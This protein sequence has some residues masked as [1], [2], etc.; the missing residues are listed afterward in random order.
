MA[1]EVISDMYEDLDS[2]ISV[3]TSDNGNDSRSSRRHR[4]TEA[5]DAPAPD[6]HCEIL[7]ETSDECADSSRK[8]SLKIAIQKEVG[9]F[10][11]KRCSR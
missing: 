11:S 1:G 2:S 6:E 7:R 5:S 3:K 9:K 4:T 8:I 10:T